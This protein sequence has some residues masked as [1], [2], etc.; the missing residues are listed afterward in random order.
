[1]VYIIV[2]DIIHFIG[3]N[4]CAPRCL[5][6]LCAI[7]YYKVC[8]YTVLYLN[9]FFRFVSGSLPPSPADSGVSDVDSSSSGHTSTDTELRAR[10][11]PHQ[12]PY[13]YGRRFTIITDHIIIYYSFSSSSSSACTIIIMPI[14][15]DIF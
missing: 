9:V 13:V 3:K 11:Q 7:Y 2:Y 15:Y 1:M 14:K 6:A 5:N 4:P 10:L 8:V 12:R